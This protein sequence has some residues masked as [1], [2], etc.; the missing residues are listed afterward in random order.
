MARS[1][2][3]QTRRIHSTIEENIMK[4]WT[5][6]TA[7]ALALALVLAATPACFAQNGDEAK[8]EAAGAALET[9]MQKVSYSIGQQLGG[10]F[11][12]QGIE[13][14]VDAMVQG[15]LDAM[16]G[17]EGQ[18]SQE[19]MQATMQAFQQEMVAKQQKMQEEAAS[20][21]QAEAD[22]FLAKNK[23]EEGVVTLESGLQYKVIEAGDGVSPKASDTVEV[24]YTGTLLD[25][26]EFDSSH[27]RGQPAKFPV[28]NVIAGWTEA[29]QL[30]K[31]GAK[32][33]L[34]IPP[35]LAY[36]PRGGG[37]LIGPNAALVFDVELLGI[38]P[39]A[40]E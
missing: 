2:R 29:L 12:Q 8:G 34:F 6:T 37:P 17:A 3:L 26:T 25:G 36:G 24:H 23:N 20:K 30:M 35:N 22:E 32:W 19:E 1:D 15:V 13:I 31:V 39:P 11:K 40:G 21:N 4:K 16:T 33:K 27:K 10:S 9:Q 7:P 18:L 28:G 38:E 5:N 14:D